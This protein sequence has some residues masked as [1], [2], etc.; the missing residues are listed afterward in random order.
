MDAPDDHGDHQRLVHPRGVRQDDVRLVVTQWQA[1]AV[2]LAAGTRNRRPATST[3]GSWPE[4]GNRPI[5][6]ITQPDVKAWI[7]RM[8]REGRNAG[9]IKL[10]Y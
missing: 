8:T 7:A 3:T 4:F 2:D 6:S 1:T 9:S 10:R 5:G